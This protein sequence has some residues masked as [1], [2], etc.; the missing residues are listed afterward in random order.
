MQQIVKFAREQLEPTMTAIEPAAG[1]EFEQFPTL[2]GL[3]TALDDEIVRLAKRLAATNDHAKVAFGTEAGL[4]QRI[5]GIP[6]VVVGPGDIDQAHT[7]DEFIEVAE[8][9]KCN[10]FLSK[11][12]RYASVEPASIR[13]AKPCRIAAG[14]PGRSEGLG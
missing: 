6:T 3:S 12:I 1:F 8:L 2:P 13:D 4:F 10:L 14:L 5:A 11:L 7:A 9:V